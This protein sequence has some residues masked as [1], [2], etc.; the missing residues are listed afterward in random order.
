MLGEWGSMD[1]MRWVPRPPSSA[2][3]SPERIVSFAGTLPSYLVAKQELLLSLFWLQILFA[4]DHGLQ[5][6]TLIRLGQDKL[7]EKVRGQRIACDLV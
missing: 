7:N 4:I 5:V 3:A 6:Q 1:F 2:S